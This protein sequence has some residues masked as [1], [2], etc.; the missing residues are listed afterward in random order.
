[1]PATLHPLFVH[2]PIALL[3]SS[4]AL[5]W[6]GRFWPGRGLDRAAWYTL[7]LG[8]AGTVVTLATGLVA[9]QGVAADS[10][11]AATLNLHRLL[12][13]VTFVIFGVLAFWHWR[14][15]GSVDGRWRVFYTLLQVVGVLLIAAV[16]FYG[17]ELVYTYGVGVAAAMP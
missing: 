1:M 9:A 14:S 13:I 17:G 8:L 3:L 15:K 10:P 11:A 12:G 6:A 7:L 4:V 16:G 2:F 5:Q